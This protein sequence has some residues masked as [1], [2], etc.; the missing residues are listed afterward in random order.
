MA[1]FAICSMMAAVGGHHPRLAA[2][3]GRHELGR[4]LAAALTRSPR[5]VIGGTSLFGGRG[6]VKSAVFGA[7]VIASIDNGLGLLGLAPARSSSSPAACCCWRC[8]STRSRARARVGRQ[9]VMAGGLPRTA[10]R[11]GPPGLTLRNS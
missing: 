5:P 1:C 2:A 6:T 9:S 8:R 4:R 7:I 10:L 11:G 3:L